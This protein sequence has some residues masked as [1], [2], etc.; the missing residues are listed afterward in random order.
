VGLH[1]AGAGTITDITAC[2]GTDTC[3]LG[4]SS[5]RALAAELRRDLKEAGIDQNA[6]AKGLH[7]KTSGCFNS[8]GQHHVADLGYLGVSRNV[9]GRRVP[10]FQL[11][12]GGQWTHNAGSY[13]LA[14]GAIPSKRV[15]EFTRKITEMFARDRQ[16]D[17]TF[18][19]FTTRIGKKAIRGM[20]EELQTLPSYEQDA[21]YYS[22]WGD[23]REYT[24]ED[25]GVGECA[26]EVVPLV[27]VGLA[28]A[29]REIFEAQLLLDE[30]KPA[31]S[32]QR[33][34]S[35]MLQAAR[36]L[37]REKNMNLSSDPDEI[38]QNFRRFF[39]DTQLFFDPYAGGK[40]ATY[41]FRIHEDKGRADSVEA[42]H[43]IIEEAQ[44]FVDAAHQC[45][46][47]LGRSLSA[48]VTVA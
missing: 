28:D 4:I 3:K 40:F 21:S 41:F 42:A 9:N 29:E 24:I 8:C 26:G 34:Y 44:Q 22:D 2:P 12:I 13:G 14:I 36:A 11:V 7:I 46:S 47:R 31:E 23:P 16:G 25:M 35:A 30:G 1:E 27:E 6:N 48:P 39:Y 5:S 17:E 19:A 38:E 45:Y 10:H 37:A 32:G 43:Q 33:A 15:P 20:V 18:Q